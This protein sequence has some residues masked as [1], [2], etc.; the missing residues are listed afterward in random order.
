MPKEEDDPWKQENTIV[1]DT[2]AK[3]WVDTA[4]KGAPPQEEA[5]P[6]P[7]TDGM[8]AQ[9][10][11]SPMPGQSQVCRPASRLEWGVF[12]CTTPF[13]SRLTGPGPG[14]SHVHP[15]S[16]ANW[17]SPG[18][19]CAWQSTYGMQCPPD[20]VRVILHTC[21]LHFTC[22]RGPRRRKSHEEA[23]AVTW[24]LSPSRNSAVAHYLL[25]LHTTRALTWIGFLFCWLVNIVVVRE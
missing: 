22:R 25:Q 8:L 17:K 1:W 23:E 4:A 21:L 5:P 16:L 20:G 18:F 12:S 15:S 10:A 9:A 14:P 3:A 2:V 24:I 7:P 13:P 19:R 11:P 6:P